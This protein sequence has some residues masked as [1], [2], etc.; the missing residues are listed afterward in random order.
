MNQFPQRPNPNLFQKIA[1]VAGGMTGGQGLFDETLYGGFNRKVA[2]WKTQIE[3][4]ERAANIE[5][6]ANTNERT[7]A[8]QVIAQKLKDQADRE[9][10]TLSQQE[11]KIKEDRAAVY[12]MKAENPAA[13]VVMPK[14]GNVRLIYP[15][16][17]IVDTGIP[18]GSM[19]DSD[20]LALEQSHDI[21]RDTLRDVNASNRIDQ[22][23]QALDNRQ[24]RGAWQIFNVPD[25][26]GGVKAVRINT[27]T[28]ETID[29]T[30]GQPGGVQT[31]IGG[32]TRPGSGAN[33]TET[34]AQKRI[35]Q[36]LKARELY[37]TIP[38]MRKYIKLGSP[39]PN[40]FY[41]VPPGSNFFGATGPTP[42]MY[43]DISMKIY[44]SPTPPAVDRSGNEMPNITIGGQSEEIPNID[45]GQPNFKPNTPAQAPGAQA[46]LRRQV[47]NDVTG[48]KRWVVSTD[49]GKTW[50][51][52]GR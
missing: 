28:G 34:P 27:L 8:M 24:E 52:E 21:T 4:A 51:F 30:T 15:G 18:T 3:P 44:G 16:G 37:N 7:M 49:G 46:P 38:E 39:G 11:L 26:K 33:A 14:G 25:G 10:F 23:Q 48:E 17:R 45:I 12:R 6:Q 29:L 22:T 32:V 31:P 5:R 40:D 50:N 43:R 2:D 41:I 20:R 35:S 1:A 9:R 13:K 47:Q 42:E 36:F 19:T